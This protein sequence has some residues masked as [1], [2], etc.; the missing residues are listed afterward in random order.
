MDCG[1]N[2]I[3]HIDVSPLKN[4][5][6]LDC[7]GC[8]I[9]DLDVSANTKLI[10]LNC[11]KNN[12]SSLDLSANTALKR[13]SCFSNNISGKNMTDMIKSIRSLVGISV[14][15]QQAE[16]ELVVIDT[17]DPKEKNICTKSD[18][19]IA[20]EL[21]WLVKDFNGNHRNRLDYEGLD[22]IVDNSPVIKITTQA[23]VGS[24]V[25]WKIS[26]NGDIKLSGISGSWVNGQSST[27]TIE[28]S[29][30]KIEGDVTYLDCSIGQLTK[31]NTELCPTLQ[32]LDCSVNNLNDIDISKNEQLIELKCEY[33]QLKS[34]NL[35]SNAQITGL[36]CYSNKLESI[37]LSANT[38]L[39]LLSCSD[40]ML[41]GLDLQN[42]VLIEKLSCSNNPFGK[43]D[44]S[45]LPK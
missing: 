28:S 14:S 15:A 17:Q 13:I 12:I 31:L 35:K 44:V 8:E 34:L 41:K 18:V 45:M 38:H 26:A 1:L 6:I 20:K 4:I 42:N 5:T 21:N 32:Y 37:D 40:N 16:G 24:K 39:R 19:A 36:W 25:N 11:H 7:S 30:I 27:F 2:P 43:L 9:T 29:D 33:N 22:D 23:K 3:T 10:R